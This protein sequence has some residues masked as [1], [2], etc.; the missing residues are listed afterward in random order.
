MCSLNGLSQDNQYKLH[1][2]VKDCILTICALLLVFPLYDHAE[3]SPVN[4]S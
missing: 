2:E 3:A 4:L 1:A